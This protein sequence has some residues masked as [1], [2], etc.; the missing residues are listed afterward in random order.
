[1]IAV[2]AANVDQKQFQG[3]IREKQQL[4]MTFQYMFN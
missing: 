1:M 2:L 3:K 4:D